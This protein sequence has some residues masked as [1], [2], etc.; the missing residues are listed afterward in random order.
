MHYGITI[1]PTDYSISPAA[2]AMA[3]EARDFESLWVPEHSHIP[4]SR[5]SAWPG[6]P[7]LPKMYYDVMDPFVAL[8]SAAS[9]TSKIK[10]ATGICLVVQRDPI[11]TAKEICSLDQIS[12]GR[13]L[14]GI[15][16]GWNAE[17]MAD[18]G[19][20]FK[21]RMGIM[22][23]RVEAIRVICSEPKPAYAGKHVNFDSFMTWPKPKQNVCPPVHIGGI[24]PFGAKRA[25]AYGDGWLPIQGRTDLIEALPKFEQMLKE[26]GRDRSSVEVSLIGAPTTADKLKALADAGVDRV[27]FGL[28]P[29]A[30]DKIL[31]LLDTYA[32]LMDAVG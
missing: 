17:E 19:T 28:P 15:G 13:F 20:D 12:N 2:L 4:L 7:E 23:E 3:A 5:L 10:L 30:E 6:G 14:F 24:F 11:Q 25:A 21:Q 22:R 31:P 18:H 1:F 29:A 32:A 27:I 9:V 8:A 26:Q 16:A